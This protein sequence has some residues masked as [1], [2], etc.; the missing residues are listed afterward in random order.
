[1]IALMEQPQTKLV[2]N[3]YDYELLLQRLNVDAVGPL[4][5]TDAA[6]LF[7]TFLDNLP[8]EYRQHYMCNCC[9]KFVDTYG[10]LVAIDEDG[11]QWSAILPFSDPPPFFHAA[12]SAMTDR[13]ERANVTGV[14][15][16]SAKVWGT[17][18]TGAWNHMHAKPP[19]ALV[20]SDRLKTPF[21]AMA[22]RAE[23]YKIVCRSLAE[24]PL[25]AVNTALSVLRTDALYRSEKV[26]GVAEWLYNLHCNL[27]GMGQHRKLRNNLIWRAVATAPVGFAHIRSSMIGTLL[28]DI[29]A[30]LP[31][32]SISRRFAEKMHPLQYQRPQA[33]PSAGNIAQAE[34][35]VEKLGIAAS[36]R[37]RFARLDEVQAMWRPKQPAHNVNGNG[38]FGHLKPKGAT[39]LQPMQVSAK[40]ITWSKFQRDVLP[41]AESIELFISASNANY[42]AL[43]TAV[44]PSAP[45]ILQWDS[46]ENR[47]P[48]SWYVY[49]GGSVPSRWGLTA[50]TYC[51][52]N[53]IC[54]QPNM[55][56]SQMTHQGQGVVFILDGAK[57]SSN[58]SLALFPEILKSE[59]R[60]VRSVIEAH[61]KTG[62]LEGQT[63]ASACG[64]ILQSSNRE[65]WRCSVRVTTGSV[66]AVYNLDRWE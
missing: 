9:R 24:Y 28:D 52:V 27:V 62:K 2:D 40:T 7:D 33:A 39:A 51:K 56:T 31:F 6:N 36:L 42:T 38:V 26:I 58:Q 34:K 59:L 29:V 65:T 30:G 35:L 64:L 8:I 53:A 21:Q 1:M 41:T 25:T 15:Y 23:D 55:W 47:N 19:S 12:I 57:D 46:E 63:E 54:L 60:E 3:D 14:F 61:S 16:S 10:G 11:M 37:R 45:P 43:C 32:E 13:V 20:F 22:E 48:V 44:D 17:P 66:T 50:N 5:T 18:T 49:N 4:F